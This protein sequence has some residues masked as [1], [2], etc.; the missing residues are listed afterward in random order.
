M[1]ENPAYLYHYHM[2]QIEDLHVWCR[3]IH[4]RTFQVI[5]LHN[6]KDTQAFSISNYAVWCHSYDHLHIKQILISQERSKMRKS[7]K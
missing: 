1:L 2:K 7:C 5:S 3:G 6:P 4:P